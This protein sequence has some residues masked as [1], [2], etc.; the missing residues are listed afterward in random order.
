MGGMN[1]A[2]PTNWITELTD[3]EL[4]DAIESTCN[5]ASSLYDQKVDTTE[6][7]AQVD[8]LIAEFDRREAD[9][10]QATN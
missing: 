2:K 7:D 3:L 4:S 1:N 6:V 10:R 5:M 8:M 9:R